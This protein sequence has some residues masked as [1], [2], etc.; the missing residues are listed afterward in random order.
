MYHQEI[1]EGFTFAGK[2]TREFNL[3][4][5]HRIADPPQEKEILEDIP[6]MQGVLDFS[7]ILGQRVYEN[8]D[9]TFI[10]KVINYDYEK[11]KVLESSISN[12]LMKKSHSRLYDDYIPGYHFWAKCTGINYEDVYEGLNIEITFDAYPFK[13]GNLLEG[14]DIWDTFNFELDVSQV[15]KFNVNGTKDITLYNVG[16]NVISPTVVSS[17]AFEII[18]DDKTFIIP[19]GVSKSDEFV[20]DL[21]ENKLTLIGNG[22]I[23]FKFYKELL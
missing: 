4:L 12:W 1:I 3:H 9:V 7:T 21:G 11:R 10:M 15:T 18:K 8:R 20:L 19:V 14:N 2:H 16:S 5:I 23:E 6:F 22:A 13:I 17:S